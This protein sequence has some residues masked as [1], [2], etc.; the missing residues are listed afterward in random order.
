MVPI[1]EGAVESEFEDK[2]VELLLEFVA[3][4]GCLVLAGEDMGVVYAPLVPS[5][6]GHPDWKGN[7]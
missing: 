2:V 5:K 3:G 1:D 7:D 6:C 4:I